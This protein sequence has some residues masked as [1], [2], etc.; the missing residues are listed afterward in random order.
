[1]NKLRRLWP[2]PLL[3]AILLAVTFL[4]PTPGHSSKSVQQVAAFLQAPY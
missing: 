3:T 2:T 4:R 1:M